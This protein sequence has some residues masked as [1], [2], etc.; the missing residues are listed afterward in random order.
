M[1]NS[2]KLGVNALS[3]RVGLPIN[4]LWLPLAPIKLHT[5]VLPTSCHQ[6]NSAPEVRGV[7]SIIIECL[8]WPWVSDVYFR[9]QRFNSRFYRF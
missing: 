6:C 4:M 5:L 3:A 1:S 2:L 7:Q 9:S 8:E